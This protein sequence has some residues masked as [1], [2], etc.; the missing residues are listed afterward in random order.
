PIVVAMQY[1]V[2]NQT[3]ITFVKEF[4]SKVIEGNSV[5]MAVQ[6]ARF[7]LGT[8]NRYEQRDFAIP[9][10]YMNALDGYL[11][12]SEVNS[13]SPVANNDLIAKNSSNSRLNSL[14]RQKEELEEQIAVLENLRNN[15]HQQLKGEGDSDKREQLRVKM[16]NYLKEIEVL[17]DEIDNIEKKINQIY[18]NL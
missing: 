16:K 11:F 17:Y 9:V 13:V 10:V 5:E 15:C 1:K 18:L 2:S 6:K 7:K 14:R 12:T 8:E 3:A 4:Y